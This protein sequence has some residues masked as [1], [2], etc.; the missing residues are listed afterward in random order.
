M[1]PIAASR[2]MLRKPRDDNARHFGHIALW[3]R[4]G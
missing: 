1:T 4:L 2:H 3:L